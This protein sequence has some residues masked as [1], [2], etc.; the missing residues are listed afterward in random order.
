M[1]IPDEVLLN[2]ELELERVKEEVEALRIAAQLLRDKEDP[3][4]AP[5]KKRAK[6]LRMP[7]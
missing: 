2:K 6:V 5:P 7:S 1:K 4:P 3:S